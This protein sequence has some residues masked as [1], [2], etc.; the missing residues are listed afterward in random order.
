M[1]IPQEILDKH[2]TW[3]IINCDLH[4]LSMLLTNKHDESI[5]LSM[6]IH[7]CRKIVKV[8]RLTISTPTDCG[9]GEG[10]DQML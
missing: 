9:T 6:D 4:Y 10:N 3:L 5:E 2:T 8:R 7:Q 1:L